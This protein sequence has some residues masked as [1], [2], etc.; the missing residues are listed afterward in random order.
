MR[1]GLS[2]WGFGFE[3]GDWLFPFGYFVDSGDDCCC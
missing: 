2:L 1:H 3:W